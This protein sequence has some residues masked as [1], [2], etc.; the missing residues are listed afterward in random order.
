MRT[1]IDIDAVAL[2]VLRE[3]A[4][5]ERRSLGKVAS[6]LILTA[7]RSRSVKPAKKRNG[8]PL[9]EREPGDVVTNEMIDAIR[10][11]EGV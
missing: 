8:I 11:A 7:V 1:T 10:E 5:V 9:L 3:L 6:E 2:D 4:A